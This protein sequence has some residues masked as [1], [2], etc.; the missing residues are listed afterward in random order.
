VEPELPRVTEEA[1]RNLGRETV[2]V[3]DPVSLRQIKEY[4]AGTGD[5][6]PLHL[7]PEYARQTPYGGI[8]A[9]PLF[10]LAAC[11]KIVSEDELGED[12]QYRDFGVPGVY[13]RSLAGEQEY[14]LCAPVRVGDVLTSRERVS[15]IREKTGRSGRLVLVTLD[16]EF[17][18]Q[19]G[20]TVARAR[21]TFIFR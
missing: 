14:E 18:N 15:A 16:S 4:L 13:G 8:V 19:C 20:E 12:G 11:R 1:W 17:T 7:D 6:H 3:S 5:A 21:Q 2:S 9:P 10:F